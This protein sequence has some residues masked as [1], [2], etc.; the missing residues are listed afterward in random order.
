MRLRCTFADRTSCLVEH[1][2]SAYICPLADGVH[3]RLPRPIHCQQS[4]R[5]GCPAM[6]PTSIGTRLRHQLDR[7]SDLYTSIY[8]QRTANERI[9]AQALALGIERP[10]LRNGAAIANRNTLISLRSLQRLRAGH[11]QGE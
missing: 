4:K 2:R 5:G 7:K 8:R 10:H 6:M 9:N 3:R 1:E 11:R